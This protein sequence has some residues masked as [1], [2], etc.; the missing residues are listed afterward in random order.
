MGASIIVGGQWGD[1]AK[2]KIASYLT[3]KDNFSV[4]CRVGHGFLIKN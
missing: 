2:G 3:L 1:E 4:A